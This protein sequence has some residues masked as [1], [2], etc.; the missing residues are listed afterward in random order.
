M[1]VR[2]HVKHTH[3][4]AL[5]RRSGSCKEN[6]TR[7]TDLFGLA[8]CHIFTATCG[9]R[10]ELYTNVTLHD[11]GALFHIISPPLP[12]HLSC[13]HARSQQPSEPGNVLTRAI[14][15]SAPSMAHE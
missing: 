2:L 10:R 8:V 11:L 3:I 7:R 14:N 12:L 5:R 1:S 4:M 9:Y 6:M 13:T 15:Q